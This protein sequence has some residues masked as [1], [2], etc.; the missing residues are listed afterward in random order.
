MKVNTPVHE[1]KR[2]CEE[3][4]SW[5]E[6]IVRLTEVMDRVQSEVIGD[7]MSAGSKQ[8]VGLQMED[9]HLVMI[10]ISHS[11]RSPLTPQKIS[12]KSGRHLFLRLME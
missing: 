7:D 9:I 11:Q 10:P 6:I 4:R 12:D 2:E 1:S 8:D 5:L 3:M